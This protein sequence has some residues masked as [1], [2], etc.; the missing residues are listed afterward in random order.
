MTRAEFAKTDETFKSACEKAGIKP[1]TR[2]ARK[3]LN[4]KGLAYKSK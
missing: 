1:T 3:Y 4:K 2:Q